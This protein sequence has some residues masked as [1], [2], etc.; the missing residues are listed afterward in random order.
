MKIFKTILLL[1][2]FYINSA[3][4]NDEAF[5]KQDFQKLTDTV[6]SLEIRIQNLE[7]NGVK[8]K[9]SSASGSNKK[10]N[11]RKLKFVHVDD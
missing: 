9:I 11:W 6:R 7:G 1:S 2:I 3:V 8:H 5:S 10:V 4:A